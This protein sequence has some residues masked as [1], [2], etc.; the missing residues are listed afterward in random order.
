MVHAGTGQT[1]EARRL[2]RASIDMAGKAAGPRHRYVRRGYYNL[3]CLSAKA[4]E[5]DRALDRLREALDH[6]FAWGIIFDDPDLAGLRGD[7]MFEAMVAEVRRRIAR[8]GATSD[9]A[10]PR[11]QVRPRP[12]RFPSTRA[13]SWRSL[14][15]GKPRR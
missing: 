2:I 13:L 5:R 10:D 14:R 12:S 15:A 9:G 3:A 4:G 1:A 7:P 6:G 8:P 11:L